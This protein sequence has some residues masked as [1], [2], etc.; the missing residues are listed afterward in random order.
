MGYPEFCLEYKSEKII[1]ISTPSTEE[2]DI[3]CV[4]AENQLVERTKIDTWTDGLTKYDL[5][6]EIRC[7]MS[8]LNF[9]EN[10]KDEEIG[11]LKASNYYNL[12]D[13]SSDETS[14]VEIDIINQL[15]ATIKQIEDIYSSN[16]ETLENLTRE[17]ELT[18]EI[19]CNPAE[20]FEQGYNNALEQCLCLLKKILRTN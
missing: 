5:E 1:I 3:I 19:N 7:L 16:K 2:V 11:Y 10:I 18:Q 8:M 17:Y 13:D 12:L 9:S 20:S 15:K 14:N 6:M 4:D